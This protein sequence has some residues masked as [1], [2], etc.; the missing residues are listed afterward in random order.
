[1]ILQLLFLLLREAEGGVVRSMGFP[2]CKHI[3][4]E[5]VFKIRADFESTKVLN[6]SERD[7]NI[8]RGP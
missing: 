8:L 7:G 6:T 4:V 1:M 3:F 2:I 5:N